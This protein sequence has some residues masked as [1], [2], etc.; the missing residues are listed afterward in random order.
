VDLRERWGP[1]PPEAIQIVVNAGPL[2]DDSWY[3]REDLYG[4]RF[5]GEACHFIDLASWWLESVPHRVQGFATPNDPNDL[6]GTIEFASGSVATLSYMTQGAKSFPKEMITLFG[7]GRSARFANYRVTQLW[8][9]DR[10][11]RTKRWRSIDKGQAAQLLSFVEAVRINSPMPISVSSLLATSRATIGL[12]TSAFEQR[13]ID[14][15]NGR[16]E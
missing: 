4:S 1:V 2:A 7:A 10:R 6:Q 11:P 14:V 3:G 12:V 5:I 8:S 15:S 9:R 13:V 16:P